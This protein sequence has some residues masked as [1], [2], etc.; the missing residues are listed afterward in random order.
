M[1]ASDDPRP[2]P[3]QV[4]QEEAAADAAVANGQPNMPAVQQAA[5]YQPAV[6]G[7]HPAV[8]EQSA[9]TAAPLPAVRPTFQVA[10]DYQNQAAP[11]PV[12]PSGTRLLAQNTIPT[13]PAPTY[14][15]HPRVIAAGGVQ[16]L[17]SEMNAPMTSAPYQPRA[18]T[19]L[20][21]IAPAEA[22]PMPQFGGGQAG[23]WGIQ[24]GAYG[25]ASDARHAVE[26]AR[27]AER[28]QLASAHSIVMPVQVSQRTLYRARLG[29]LSQSAAV[30]ACQDIR[31]RSPCMVLSPD[32]ISD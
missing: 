19:G 32:A 7:Y 12:V 14:Y 29:G 27:H 3:G 17:S 6:G 15:A 5:N 11:A 18:A 28:Y 16:D 4:D 1:V 9:V 31:G 24:V 26:A 21:L 2:T 23:G 20:H 8:V 13:P 22:A 10:P 25:S 30:N